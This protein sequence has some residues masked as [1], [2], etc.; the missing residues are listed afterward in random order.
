MYQDRPE[1]ETYNL[2][3][4]TIKRRYCSEY[5]MVNESI[6]GCITYTDFTDE[7][8][9]EMQQDKIKEFLDKHAQAIRERSEAGRTVVL[10]GGEVDIGNR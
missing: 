6:V 8:L 10:G 7:E 5:E 2:G 4:H 3:T 9:T 1:Q